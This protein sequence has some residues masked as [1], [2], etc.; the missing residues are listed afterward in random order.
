MQTCV[1]QPRHSCLGDDAV[2]KELFGT[3]LYQHLVINDA[4]VHAQIRTTPIA[5]QGMRAR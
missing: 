1:F 2:K 5:H 4:R 3:S